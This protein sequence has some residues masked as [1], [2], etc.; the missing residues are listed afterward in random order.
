MRFVYCQRLLFGKLHASSV[1]GSKFIISS[2]CCGIPLNTCFHSS[3]VKHFAVK[4]KFAN[5]SVLE[6]IIHFSAWILWYEPEVFSDELRDSADFPRFHIPHLT[7]GIVTAEV[8]Q[9]IGRALEAEAR[10][11]Q[12]SDICLL[13]LLCEQAIC[14][15]LTNITSSGAPERLNFPSEVI[16]F[17][18]NLDTSSRSLQRTLASE[19]LPLATLVEGHV[20]LSIPG[21]VHQRRAMAQRKKNVS[22]G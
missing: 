8:L 21:T 12:R 2:K 22:P 11:V 6:E 19:A 20:S 17:R 15:K 1:T 13:R 3:T 7:C 14:L 16:S 4:S 10:L 18:A 9:S 5:K